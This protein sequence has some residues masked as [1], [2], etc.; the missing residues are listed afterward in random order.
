[1]ETE[2]LT[3]KI[4]PMPTWGWMGILLVVV[5]AWRL[6]SNK[7]SAAATV[8]TTS[9][10]Q[11]TPSNV[12][13]FISQSYITNNIPAEPSEP[14]TTGPVPPVSKPPVKGPQPPG[15][16]PTKRPP[17][18]PKEK[19][20]EYRVKKGDTLSSIAKRYHTTVAAIWKYN[21]TP[22]NRPAATIKTLEKRGQN[23]IFRNEQIDIAIPQ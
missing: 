5:L 22:G 17:H 8:Q 1:M 20:I 3:K 6:Y 12:P 10:D 4:G 2:L 19:V 11:T 14:V 9:A 15:K 18:P 16:P 21:T 7:K 23:L 13:E